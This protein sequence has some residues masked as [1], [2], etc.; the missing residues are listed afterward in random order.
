MGKLLRWIREFF[1]ESKMMFGTGL[2]Y[3]LGFLHNNSL[4]SILHQLVPYQFYDFIEYVDLN[5]SEWIGKYNNGG[6]QYCL[7][8]T[9]ESYSYDFES[10]YSHCLIDRAFMIFSKVGK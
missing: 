1:C 6:L 2:R 9:C 10:H 8:Q 4:M 3:I 7:R 5:K